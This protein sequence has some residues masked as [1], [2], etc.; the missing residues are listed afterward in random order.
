MKQLD[1]DVAERA[2][3]LTVKGLP[4]VVELPEGVEVGGVKAKKKGKFLTL[5]M[6]IA[7]N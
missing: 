1:L 3:R 4:A 5:R 6:P 2:V 7:E